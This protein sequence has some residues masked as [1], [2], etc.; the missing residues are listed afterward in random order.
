MIFTGLD[1]KI[2]TVLI[3]KFNINSI[4]QSILEKVLPPS[5]N[6][7]VVSTGTKKTTENKNTPT[8]ALD[9][10]AQAPWVELPVWI[11]SKPL[12]QESLK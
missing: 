6:E 4:E 3:Q 7:S 8:L 9:G 1:K 11:N 12:T 2:E 10:S 5:S